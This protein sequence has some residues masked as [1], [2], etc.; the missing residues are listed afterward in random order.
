MAFVFS[1]MVGGKTILLNVMNQ[2]LSHSF[3]STHLEIRKI[4]LSGGYYYAEHRDVELVTQN[5]SVTCLEVTQVASV[6][7]WTVSG[8]SRLLGC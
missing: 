2:D 4:Q 6:R 5:T 3:E 7:V 1:L 8:V